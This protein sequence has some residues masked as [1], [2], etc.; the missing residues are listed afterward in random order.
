MSE[1]Y[2]A[3]FE[4]A[5]GFLAAEGKLTTELHGNLQAASTAARTAG[6]VDYADALEEACD[7]VRLRLSELGAERFRPRDA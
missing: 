3:V 2:K 4:L 1:H 5:I 7:H 6:F